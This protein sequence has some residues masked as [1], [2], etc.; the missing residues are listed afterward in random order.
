MVDDVD[1]NLIRE[2]SMPG[3]SAAEAAVKGTDV[4]CTFHTY[5]TYIIYTLPSKPCVVRRDF[6]TVD[7]CM[8]VMHGWHAR[9]IYGQRTVCC[10]LLPAAAAC[11]LVFAMFWPNII[12]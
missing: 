7:K 11:V 5:S 1:V 3:I 2:A 6:G 12:L 8:F 10:Y 4:F 9:C